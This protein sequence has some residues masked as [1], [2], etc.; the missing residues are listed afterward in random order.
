MRQSRCADSSRGKYG[1]GC[2]KISAYHAL[3]IEPPD[4]AVPGEMLVIDPGT[5]FKI[6]LYRVILIRRLKIPWTTIGGGKRRHQ[7]VTLS[8]LQ[9]RGVKKMKRQHEQAGLGYSIQ[10]KNKYTDMLI[11]VKGIP[12]LANSRKVILSP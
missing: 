11:I 8:A 3:D 4:S 5:V 2:I 9:D 7:V 6:I 1:A 10:K 12:T